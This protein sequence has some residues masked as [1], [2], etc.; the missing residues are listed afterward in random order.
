MS[1]LH[2][3]PIEVVK[4]ELR[5]ARRKEKKYCSTID[6]SWGT[7]GNEQAEF[8]FRMVKMLERELLWLELENTPE[9]VDTSY[10]NKVNPCAQ[11]HVTPTLHHW[12]RYFQL[13]CPDCGKRIKP[14]QTKEV[15]A[16]L[17]NN[18]QFTRLDKRSGFLI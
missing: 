6:H 12:Q 8:Y 2:P 4:K 16:H 13:I 7:E 15:A 5:R 10:V 9:V 11:C 3:T 1:W 14:S 17:W 18:E